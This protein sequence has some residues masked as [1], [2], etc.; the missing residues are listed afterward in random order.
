MWNTK[1]NENTERN[2][3]SS[4]DFLA[5]E[6]YFFLSFLSFLV[7]NIY[8]LYKYFINFPHISLCKV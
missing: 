5:Q 2:F 7:Y 3:K 1:E 4:I 8:C 6:M